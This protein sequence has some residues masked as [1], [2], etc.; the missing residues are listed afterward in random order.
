MRKINKKLL[1]ITGSIL[2]L[3]FSYLYR[4]GSNF[5]DITK[6]P[7]TTANADSIVDPGSSGS[8][9]GGSS[10]NGGSSDGACSCD[11]G[12]GSSSTDSGGNGSGSSTDSDSS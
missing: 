5:V 4:D 10:T 12:D 7:G 11:S 1:L 3:F 6:L 9:S 2:T 8:V